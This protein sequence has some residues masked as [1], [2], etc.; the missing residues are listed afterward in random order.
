MATK[1]LGSLVWASLSVLKPG[2]RR[3]FDATMGGQKTYRSLSLR[4]SPTKIPQTIHPE[5]DKEAG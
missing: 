3:S 1:S 2:D 4:L 5:G